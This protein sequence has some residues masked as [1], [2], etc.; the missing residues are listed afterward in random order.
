MKIDTKKEK[1][2][3][4]GKCVTDANRDCTEDCVAFKF[5]EAG[6]SAYPYCKCHH[7]WITL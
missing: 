3:V 7:F 5:K 4:Y 1:V 6:L 2:I